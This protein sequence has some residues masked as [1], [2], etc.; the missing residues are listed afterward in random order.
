MKFWVLF[1]VMAIWVCLLKRQ[2][3]RR[4]DVLRS[5]AKDHKPDTS[6]PMVQCQYCGI[7]LPQSEAWPGERGFFCD[8][9]HLTAS[10]KP[11]QHHEADS[12]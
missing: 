12:A 11:R 4:L 8:K 5:Q 10:E 7:Y 3:R 9:N 6:K 2:H 1:L